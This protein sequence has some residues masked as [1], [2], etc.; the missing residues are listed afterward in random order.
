MAF[1]IFSLKYYHRKASIPLFW[2]T[3]KNEKNFGD[4]LS[5]Y[6]IS[7]LT[8]CKI[9]PIYPIHLKTN[10]PFRFIFRILNYFLQYGPISFSNNLLRMRKRHVVGLGSIINVAN[11]NSIVWGS[12]IMSKMDN[13]READFRIVRGPL[14][15]E[16][17]KSLGYKSPIEIGDPGLLLSLLYKSQNTKK[18][19]VGIIPH[20]KDYQI[21]SSFI[22]NEEILIINLQTIDV[23]KILDEIN[24]CEMLI[25]SSLH[26]LIISHSYGIPALWFRFGNSIVGDESKYFDYYYSVEIFNPICFEIDACNLNLIDDI[27]NLFNRYQKISVPHKTIILKRCNQLLKTAPFEIKKKYLL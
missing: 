7:E 21:L 3:Y 2:S 10:N 23:K 11:K 6:I 16:R 22:K 27:V 25:S 4:E 20:V 5:P 18:Y 9:K 17:I 15:Q 1:S 19:R 24:S 13:I 12:G 8:G 14:T 26:G